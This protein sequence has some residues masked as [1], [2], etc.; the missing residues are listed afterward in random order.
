M[1]TLCNSELLL[2]QLLLTK[3]LELHLLPDLSE[4]GRACGAGRRRDELPR[5]P[6]RQRGES[7]VRDVRG[8]LQ[9][10]TRRIKLAGQRSSGAHLAGPAASARP[11]APHCRTG[12][13]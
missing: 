4:G 1:L 9:R 7:N 11:H 2:A 13:R 8:Q 10:R 3:L 5:R 12:R 6:Q